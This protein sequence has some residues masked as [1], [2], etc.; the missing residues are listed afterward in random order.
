MCAFVCV[1]EGCQKM[2]GTL[3][4][5]PRVMSGALFEGHLGCIMLCMAC[6]IHNTIQG[7]RVCSFRWV[8]DGGW[9]WGCECE[10]R[11]H[12]CVWAACHVAVSSRQTVCAW[13][14]RLCGCCC[15]RALRMWGGSHA[16]PQRPL[17][18][19]SAVVGWACCVL[20]CQ[21]MLQRRM[22]VRV[23]VLSGCLQSLFPQHYPQQA[24]ILT[25]CLPASFDGP[26]TI[27]KL[28]AAVHMV[29]LVAAVL[30]LLLLFLPSLLQLSAGCCSCL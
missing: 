27:S 18:P 6:G 9:W 29:A 30:L 26:P 28:H 24:V 11:A 12:S 7:A 17:E 20:L 16:N 15:C 19:R 13:W 1:L 21:L 25:A 14:C 22:C 2:H 5:L 4:I 3:P 8:W 10:C 23:C